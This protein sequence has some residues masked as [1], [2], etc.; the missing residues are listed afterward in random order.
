MSKIQAMFSAKG[1][2]LF[3]S[4]RREIDE[5]NAE[6]AGVAGPVVVVPR[7][8]AEENR[9]RIFTN[10]DFVKLEVRGSGIVYAQARARDAVR[11]GKP[12]VQPAQPEKVTYTDAQSGM[13][14][15]VLRGRREKKDT[16][17]SLPMGEQ[18]LT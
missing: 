10:G 7:P 15:T 5:F 6:Y 3:D 8:P 1:R 13:R 14:V 18:R 12:L 4:E 2:R 17:F 9:R 11:L 16:D